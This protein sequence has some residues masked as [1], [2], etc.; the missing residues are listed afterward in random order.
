MVLVLGLRLPR[1][2]EWKGLSVQVDAIQTVELAMLKDERDN[3]HAH[4]SAMSIAAKS[5]LQ[6]GGRHTVTEG[7]VVLEGS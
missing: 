4:D 7:G 2:R 5:C 3:D 1:G 6:F